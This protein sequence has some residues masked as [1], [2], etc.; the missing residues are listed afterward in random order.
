MLPNPTQ[1]SF[2]KLI[3]VARILK[4][5]NGPFIPH[6]NIYLICQHKILQAFFTE[7]HKPFWLTHIPRDHT[8]AMQFISHKCIFY[9]FF[10][11]IFFY[12]DRSL[13]FHYKIVTGPFID[14]L[15]LKLTNIKKKIKKVAQLSA[16]VHAL[17][18]VFWF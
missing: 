3:S 6:C 1:A 4:Y 5:D 10:I 7:I 12:W 11:F 9:A 16:Q 13:Q 8:L 17:N 14:K 2:F 15:K 18:L